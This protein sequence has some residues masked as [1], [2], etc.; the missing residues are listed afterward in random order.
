MPTTT[1]CHCGKD[2]HYSNPKIQKMIQK[3]INKLG[4]TL[5]IQY[6]ETIYQV[7]RHYIALHGVIASELP[8]LNFDSKR[9]VSTPN[10]CD[11]SP[12]T[13]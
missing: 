9:I 10:S 7:P 4:E 2:L 1:K 12:D 5:D 11:F 3:L 8:S 6:Q 13:F